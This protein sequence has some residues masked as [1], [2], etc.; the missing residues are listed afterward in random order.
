MKAKTVFST[1]IV[2]LASLWLVA[3]SEDPQYIE[4]QHFTRF[5]NSVDDLA[6]KYPAI[7]ESSVIEFFTYGCGH[8]QKFAPLL[9]K[10]Q[11]QKNIKVQ[12]VPVV[13]DEKTELHAKAFYFAAKQDSFKTLHEGLFILVAGFGRTDSI[14]DQKIA[15][16]EWFQQQGIQPIETLQALTSSDNEEQL[17]LSVLLSKR[18]KITGTPTLVVNQQYRINNK[19]VTSQQELL[20]IATSLLEE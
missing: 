20:D 14:E 3:C 9:A 10:W 17:A 19:S 4:E 13:W 11:K 1:L 18:F 12:Y 7:N 16:I 6:E 8:C 15:L 2:M 5:E